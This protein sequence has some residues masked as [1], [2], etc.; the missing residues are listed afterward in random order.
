MPQSRPFIVVGENIHCTL[1]YKTSGTFV[2]TMGDGTSALRYTEGGKEHTVAIPERFTTSEEWAKG[3]VKHA[4]AAMWQGIYGKGEA[5]QAATAYIEYM[6]RKQQESGAAYLD[7]NV[8]EFSTDVA[9]R[10]K[11]MRWTAGIMQ[12][13]STLPLSVDSSNMRILEAG[14]SACDRARGKPMVNSVSLERLEALD[15]AKRYGAVVLAGATGA[16][17]M[18]ASVAERLTNLRTL[19]G[20]IGKAG[21]KHADVFFDPLVFPVSV[22]PSN[23]LY[24]IESIRALR[25]EHG[26]EVHF[27]PGLSNIS[28]GMP[29]RKLLNQVYAWLCREAGMDGAIANPLHINGAILDGL[30]VKGE[31]FGL[32]RAF[33][34]AEDQFGIEY[35]S[36][37]REGKV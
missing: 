33:L 28:F 22:D 29:N 26:G 9:E 20:H 13:A 3:N 24:V 7:L 37:S 6:A 34:L 19:M 18:P 10:E 16:T 2:K 36:A 32:A 12:K 31:Q 30:D 27:A 1:V 11:V 4:A 23:G 8:D 25:K 15:V 21:I 35:I 5:Q 17:S 14:L